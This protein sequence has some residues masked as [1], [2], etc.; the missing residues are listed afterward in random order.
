MLSEG[1]SSGIASSSVGP[2]NGSGSARSGT[3]SIGSEG[4][5]V[6]SN[7]VA[8]EVGA[9][10]GGVSEDCGLGSATAIGAIISPSW[11]NGCRVQ[12]VWPLLT[13]LDVSS[14]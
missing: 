5:V 11:I 12:R 9:E 3:V 1:A 10:E 14:A 4:G 6:G 13:A 2:G 8:L 7:V